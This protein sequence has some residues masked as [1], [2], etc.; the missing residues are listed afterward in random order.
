MALLDSV[1]GFVGNNLQLQ[2][3][4]DSFQVLVEQ[5]GGFSGL[6]KMF[7]KEG[8]GS[9]LQ[10]WVSTNSNLPIS[11][12]QIRQVLGAQFIHDVARKMDVEPNT[13]IEK[14]SLILPKIID[15]LSPDGKLPEE[16][17]STAL[18]TVATHLMK[19]EYL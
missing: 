6:K 1:K 17:D 19:E 7:E 16:M 13:A 2:G 9:I 8:A 4:V 5:S 11:S 14:L 10:S 12:T 18:I 3:F 15:R